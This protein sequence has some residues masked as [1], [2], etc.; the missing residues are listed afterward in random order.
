MPRESNFHVDEAIVGR[1]ARIPH[2]DEGVKLGR[3][4]DGLLVVLDSIS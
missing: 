3:I 2:L 1:L 4:Y